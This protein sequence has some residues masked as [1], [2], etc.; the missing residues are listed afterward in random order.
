MEPISSSLEDYLEA[1]FIL[2]QKHSH[3]RLTDI[4]EFMGVSKRVSTAPSAISKR[5]VLSATRLTALYALQRKGSNEP[6]AFC[7]ATN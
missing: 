1:I 4:A 3:V 2:V 7:A 5:R 6:P